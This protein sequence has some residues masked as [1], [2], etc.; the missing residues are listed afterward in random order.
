MTTPSGDK[1]QSWGISIGLWPGAPT[2]PHFLPGG[3]G[4]RGIGFSFD[5]TAAGSNGAP[6]PGDFT[7]E[8]SNGIVGSLQSVWI[9]NRLNSAN[10]FTLS[11]PTLGQVISVPKNFQGV[12]PIIEPTPLRFIAA[13]AG[14][15]LVPCIFLNMPAAY[16]SALAS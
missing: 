14:L 3:V 10:N 16:Y 9:D 2:D 12:F 5:F 15:V 7:L 8:E 13:S 11:F 1:R 6:I 4:P